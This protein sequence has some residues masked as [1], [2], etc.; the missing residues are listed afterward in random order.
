M[1]DF[2]DL[3]KSLSSLVRNILE[4][5]FWEYSQIG[6]CFRRLNRN[7]SE[8]SQMLK[9]AFEM[10]PDQIGNGLENLHANVYKNYG[11]L[12][13]ALFIIIDIG[14]AEF[15]SKLFLKLNF[16]DYFKSYI[17]EKAD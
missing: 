14:K 16:N 10:S 15:A 11:E 8:L 6:F 2:D 5:L 12:V 13:T 1:S 4:G 3:R 9:M 17:E 7:I